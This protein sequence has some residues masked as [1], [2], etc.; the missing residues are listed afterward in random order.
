[1]IDS[2]SITVRSGSGGNGVVSGRREKFVPRGGPD[3]GDG[4]SGGSVDLLCDPSDTTL[5]WFRHKARF[6]AYDGG[7]GQ[8]RRRRGK[9][10]DSI[11]L[12]VPVG[13]EVW[14]GRERVADMTEPGAKVVVAQGGRGGRG[15]ASFATSTSRYPLLAEEGDPGVEQALRLELKLLADVGIIGAP[16]AGK[17][18]L[19]AVVS[20]ARPKVADYP[21]TTLEP[22]LGV[23]ER[24][25]T[26]FVMVDIPG[27]IEGAHRGV[28]LGQEF[29]RHVERTRVLIHL[30][31][32]SGEAVERT[33][34]QTKNELAR[35]GAGLDRK[36]AIVAVNKMDIPEVSSKRVELR[37]LGGTD[38]EVACISAASGEG[39][40]ELLDGVLVLLRETRAVEEQAAEDAPASAVPVLRPQE[41]QQKPTVVRRGRTYRVQHR[42]AERLAAMVDKGDGAAMLQLLDQFRRRGVLSALEKAGISDGDRARVGAVEWEWE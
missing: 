19:L 18:S 8:G 11:T 22:V 21:F 10:G 24:R 9:D 37:G 2:V 36:P 12:R 20:A 33:Y 16:N 23:V 14:T 26:S 29:L 34:E 42:P 4:G 6:A 41:T 1:M 7:H 32:G 39:V 5:A 30:V 25:G 27:L 28:G 17:S 13:T 35:F 38:R 40:G 15:N 3:G 31:D